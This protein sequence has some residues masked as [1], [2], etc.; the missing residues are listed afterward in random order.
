MTHIVRCQFFMQSVIGSS[1]VKG[2]F[3]EKNSHAWRHFR[4][5]R[6]EKSREN[7]GYASSFC[8]FWLTILR[9]RFFTGVRHVTWF[10]RCTWFLGWLFWASD[11]DSI[12]YQNFQIYFEENNTIHFRNPHLSLL[13]P[14]L[15]HTTKPLHNQSKYFEYDPFI[16]YFNPMSPPST[17]SWAHK[18]WCQCQF[19]K[20]QDIRFVIV[21]CRARSVRIPSIR[22]AIR[23]Y[24]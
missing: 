22:C 20:T 6:Y 19:Q 14:S 4:P 1:S 2:N 21:W 13:F 18:S 5:D 10:Y 15:L 23:P 12:D 7:T 11:L 16:Q 9:W 3:V 8:Q 24:C 17:I